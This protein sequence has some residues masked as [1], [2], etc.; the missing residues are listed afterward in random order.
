MNVEDIIAQVKPLATEYYRLTGKPLGAAGEIGNEKWLACF[1]F[2]SKAHG[3]SGYDA[4]DDQGMRY[5]IK[6]RSLMSATAT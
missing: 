2:N 6:A 4:E 1:I 5:Q 3:S